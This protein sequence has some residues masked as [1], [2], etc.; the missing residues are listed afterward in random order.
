MS[1]LLQIPS[2]RGPIACALDM[3]RSATAAV[4]MVGGGD[5]G[6]NGPAEAIYPTLA[7]DLAEAEIAALRLD[8]RTHR[9]P[10]IV[11]EAVYDVHAALAYLAGRGIASVGLLGHSFG[12]AVVIEAAV[13]GAGSAAVEAVVTLATQTAGA[14]RVG[15][16]APRPLLLVHGLADQRLSPQCSQQLHRLAGEPK[17]L[18]LYEGATH[19]LRQ[20]RE[21]L[22]RLLRDWLGDMLGGTKAAS[23]AG[24]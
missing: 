23:G 22:R 21:E 12:G 2:G 4:V 1:E 24:G 20:R 18:V 16:L 3:P 8:F 14:Q 7:E 19:S 10:G 17:Q 15:E 11:E 9:F 13:S 6:L 5:G